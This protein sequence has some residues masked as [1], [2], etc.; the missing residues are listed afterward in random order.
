MK[1]LCFSA[2]SDDTPCY[3]IELVIAIIED[4]HY[5]NFCPSF[6]NDSHK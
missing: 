2:D 5:G 4:N 6:I 1:L 3:Y